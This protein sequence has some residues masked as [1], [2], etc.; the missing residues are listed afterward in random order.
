M[1]LLIHLSDIHFRKSEVGSNQDPNH[2]LRTEI[3]KDVKV[4]CEKLGKKADAII[5][6]GDIAFA[7]HPDEYAFATSWLKELCGQCGASMADI[8]VCPGNHDVD[9]SVADGMLVQLIHNRIKDATDEQRESTIRGFISDKEAARLLYESLDNYNLFA[10]Q[11][12]CDLL[13]PERTR[14]T[15]DLKLNDGSVLRLWGLNSCFVS[16]S[17]DKEGSLFLDTASFQITRDPGVVNLVAMHHHLDWL[18]QRQQIDD[19]LSDVAAIQLLGHVHTSRIKMDRDYLRIVASAAQPDRRETG[20]EPGYNIMEIE[21]EGTGE[22]RTL[23][24]RTH[25]R[26]WQ[27][28][29]SGFKAKMD[30]SKD[31]F[32]HPIKL[33]CW[34][35]PSAP[36]IETIAPLPQQPAT[37]K[38]IAMAAIR[39]IG[40]QFYQLSFSQKSAIAGQLGL[41]EEEDMAAPDFERFRRVFM[42]A[43]ERGLIEEL[44]GAIAQARTE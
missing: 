1:M 13:P 40:V 42:R 35:A 36:Q 3:L 38:L 37:A 16:S 18:R 8:F 15:R 23:V 41:L 10:Q 6:S 24:T 28:A 25:I 30:K 43:Q 7:G 27:T 2:F 39:E 20:W 34:E 26:I 4:Q 31:V 5:L 29:P 11:F 22:E 33:E 21:I 32:V 12:L 44:K 9:R 17:H 19:H 14:A